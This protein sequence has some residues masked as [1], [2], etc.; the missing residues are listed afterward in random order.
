MSYDIDLLIS[1]D[2]EVPSSEQLKQA[3]HTMSFIEDGKPPKGY[4]W[5]LDYLNPDTGVTFAFR[6]Q[7]PPEELISQRAWDTGLQIS[8]PTTCPTFVARE[9]LP[10]VTDF[11]KKFQLWLYLPNG[12]ILER[13]EATQL[14]TTWIEINRRTISRATNMPSNFQPFYFPQDKLD[15]MWR[16]QASRPALLKRY[17]SLGVYVPRVVLMRNKINKHVVYRTSMWTDLSPSV[18][19]D[20][21]AFVINK[22]AKLTFGRFPSGEYSSVFVPRDTIEAIIKPYLRRADRPI[23]HELIENTRSIKVPIFKE[24]SQHLN[25]P[26]HDYETANIEDT[27]DVATE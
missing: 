7:A 4:V 15:A 20:V 2:R 18:I 1:S 6:Y 11:C 27:I 12:G 8:I 19:P 24:L 26:L 22:P 25:F 17:S 14:L 23:P 10:I 16:Y 3:V 21:D 13:Y 9:S 5:Q